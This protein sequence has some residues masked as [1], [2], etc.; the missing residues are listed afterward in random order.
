M[1]ACIHMPA[2]RGAACSPFSSAQLPNPNLISF[3]LLLARYCNE[4]EVVKAGQRAAHTG[5]TELEAAVGVKTGR[6]GRRH[7]ASDV[8]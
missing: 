2:A 4:N 7:T 5:L 6:K 1:L 3:V 8:R